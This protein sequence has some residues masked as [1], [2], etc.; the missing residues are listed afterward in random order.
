MNS[1][2]LHKDSDGV[3]MI[4]DRFHREPER[5]NA[6]TL[7]HFSRL[8]SDICVF[9]KLRLWGLLFFC[10]QDLKAIR[11]IDESYKEFF[12]ELHAASAY[13]T[14]VEYGK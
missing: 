4:A 6:A 14:K 9:S 8:L 2:N 7:G 12:E 13:F 10:Q 11:T 1:H 3:G 5:K